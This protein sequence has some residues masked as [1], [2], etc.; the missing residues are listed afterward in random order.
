LREAINAFD[1]M[2]VENRPVEVFQS[3]DSTMQVLKSSRLEDYGLTSGYHALAFSLSD[4]IGCPGIL[5]DY[6]EYS[7]LV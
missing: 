5:A 3:M 4:L 1:R 7:H 6:L 2:K